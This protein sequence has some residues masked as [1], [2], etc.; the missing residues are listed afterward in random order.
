MAIRF[1]QSIVPISDYF[2]EMEFIAMSSFYAILKNMNILKYLE[3]GLIETYVGDIIGEA[4]KI[5]QNPQMYIGPEQLEHF[6]CMD[7][8]YVVAL[9]ING[10]QFHYND[11]LNIAETINNISLSWSLGLA[12][13]AL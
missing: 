6:L 9:L 2:R 13:S 1:I 4:M 7:I 10:Y 12:V 11:R 5:C 8:S 3:H